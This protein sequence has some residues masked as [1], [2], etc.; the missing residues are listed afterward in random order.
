[1]TF[2]YKHRHGT[3][4][5]SIAVGC[6]MSDRRG[7]TAGVAAAG[8]LFGAQRAVVDGAAELQLAVSLV[9]GAG[10][11]RHGMEPRSIQQEPR[12]AVESGSGAEVLCPC[13]RAGGGADVGRTLHGGWHADRGLGWAQ[14]LSPQGR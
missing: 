10:N 12:P 8:F 5:L 3:G 11:R 2:R 1:M 9:C 4:A 6:S 14:E 13:E 7:V